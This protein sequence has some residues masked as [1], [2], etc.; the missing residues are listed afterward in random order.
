MYQLLYL[1][2]RLILPVLLFCILSFG[3]TKT[4][5]DL[6]ELSILQVEIGDRMLDLEGL[7]SEDIPVGQPII[8]TFSEAVDPASVPPAVN[9]FENV[10]EVGISTHTED[11]HTT[12][13]I[14]PNVPLQPDT[15]YRLVLSTGLR[16]ASGN[17]FIGQQFTFRTRETGSE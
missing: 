3:C 8:I 1:K 2:M 14:N 11:S 5:D 7:H 17:N 15:S 10:H 12:I 13:I 16:S 6:A 9:L 4:E